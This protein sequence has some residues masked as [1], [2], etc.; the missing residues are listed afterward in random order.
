MLDCKEFLAKSLF[1]FGGFG[2]N[3]YNIQLLELG[4]TPEQTM[5]NTPIIVN[6]TV[7]GIEVY[8]H[9]YSPPFRIITVCFDFDLIFL[10]A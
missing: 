7:N 1:L 3:D 2:G 9:M 5:K 8:I 6:A 10:D 4:L